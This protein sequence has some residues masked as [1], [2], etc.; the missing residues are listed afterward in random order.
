M[1]TAFFPFPD[2]DA[3]RNILSDDPCYPKIP[4]SQREAI[5][6]DAWAFGMQAADEMWDSCPHDAGMRTL[7]KSNGLKLE[8]RNIDYVVGNT[9]YFCDYVSGEG[10]ITIYRKSVALWAES[11]GLSYEDSEELILAH[12]MFH[13]LE[14]HRFGLASRRF[15]VPMLQIGKLRIGKTGIP[16]LSEIAANAFANRW[17]T[18]SADAGKVTE[19]QP[20]DTQD[21]LPAAQVEKTERTVKQLFK[22]MI[23]F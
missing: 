19:A 11:N 6:E 10:I 4:E 9:R 16:A 17:Y 12:E 2:R 7:L 1:D 21:A 15:L 18:L 23:S 22:R 3:C 20:P 5:F 13:Y 8:R 14:S